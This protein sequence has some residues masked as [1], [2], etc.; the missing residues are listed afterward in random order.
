MKW[1]EIP[2]FKEFGIINSI[3]FG[4]ILF[5]DFINEQIENS[6]LQLNPEFQRGHVWTQNQ[7]EKYIEFILRGGKSGRDFYFNLNPAS[8]EYVCVDGLQRIMSFVKFVNG[9]IK[10]FGQY[11]HEFI[12][13]KR[14]AGG[15]PLPEY[16]VN[17][18]INQ[19][20]DQKEILGWYIDLNSGGTPHTNDDIERVRNMI[21]E[22]L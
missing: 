12:I 9:N 19:L 6:D 22:L 17:V 18:H 1:D 10:V 20:E 8:N 5:V 7:Q 16:K 21:R 13:N 14:I 2:K 4:F 3:S 15:Q 11:F